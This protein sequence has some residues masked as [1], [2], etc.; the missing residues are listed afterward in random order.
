[1]KQRGGDKLLKNMTELAEALQR[2]FEFVKRIK[3]AGFPMP[4]GL[5]DSSQIDLRGK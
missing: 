4:G 2:P 1:M 5:G 3:W